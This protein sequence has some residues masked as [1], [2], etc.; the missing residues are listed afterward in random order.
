MKIWWK[1]FII[2]IIASISSIISGAIIGNPVLLGGGT[3]VLIA[4]GTFGGVFSVGFYRKSFQNL[5]LKTAE[6]R[7]WSYHFEVE[8]RLSTID[9]KKIVTKPENIKIQ[10][11]P[12]VKGV[13]L[14]VGKGKYFHEFAPF[15]Q[16]DLVRL[17]VPSEEIK[18]E[19]QRK[20]KQAKKIA[21][22]N[23]KKFEESFLPKP[24]I[25]PEIKVVN[26]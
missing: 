20:F 11:D 7:T 22:E 4:F 9:G 21:D 25:I 10:V 18:Q 19:W 3:A 1:L 26:D 6:L 14:S 23:R 13:L 5:P 15:Y 8:L 2:S 24:K 16:P 12:S 17:T